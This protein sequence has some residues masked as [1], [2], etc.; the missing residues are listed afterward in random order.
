MKRRQLIILSVLSGIVFFLAWPPYGFPVLL[1]FGFVPLLLI[2]DEICTNKEKYSKVSMLFYAYLAFF[3]WNAATTWWIF[4]STIFGGFAALIVNP[5]FLTI[6]FYLFHITKRVFNR[7][8]SYLSFIFFWITFEFIN[9]DGDL[10][11]PWLNIGNGFAAYPQLVQW[12]E[13]TGFLGGTLWVLIINVLFFLILKEA[14]IKKNHIGK[15]IRIATILT[16]L[17]PVAISIFI[18]NTYKEKKDPYTIVMPNID[19]YKEKF[20]TIKPVDQLKRITNLA[21]T[22]I[23]ANTDYLIGPETSI[24]EGFWENN[25]KEAWC[26]DSLLKI[27]DSFP[28]LKIVIGLSSYRMYINGLGRTASAR[29]YPDIANFYYDAYN[30]AIYL[31]SSKKIQLYHKSKLVPGVEKM[32]FSRYLKFM[33]NFALNMGGSTGTYGFQENRTPFFSIDKKVNVAPVICY[34]SAYGEF[35]S[36]YVKN[37]ANLIFII[38]NDGWWGN[39]AGYKQHLDYAR[40]RAIETRRSIARCANTG[41]SCFIDQRGNFIQK[42]GWWTPIC[43][44][45]TINAND[46]ITFY[47][48]YGD[49]IGRILQYP[50]YLTLMI[51]LFLYIKRTLRNG[52]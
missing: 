25:I 8:E 11:W 15:N 44:K 5:F 19:P 23:D 42:S 34:E 32:P 16:I 37:G 12:Y 33:N 51:L 3:I 18:Y 46:Q 2:E 52:T 41:I 35:V 47:V 43:M 24:P 45:N 10:S 50:T 9:C 48:R 21:K 17:L 13:Y 39:T 40:L 1:F 29:P 4:K 27:I 30:T 7:K 36:K 14:I 28:Q 6:P 49:Y 31:D 22:Q 26:V 38:T 20:G